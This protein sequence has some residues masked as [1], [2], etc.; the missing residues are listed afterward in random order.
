[1]SRKNKTV[2]NTNKGLLTTLCV[3]FGTVIFEELLAILIVALVGL[4][5]NIHQLIQNIPWLAHCVINVNSLFENPITNRGDLVAFLAISAQITFLTTSLLGGLSDKTERIYWITYPEEYLI[6]SRLNFENLSVIS[7]TSIGVQFVIMLLSYNGKE[8]F[9]NVFFM[10]AF[11]ISIIAIVILNYRF[12][13]VF[14]NREKICK[15]KEKEFERLLDERNAYSNGEDDNASELSK[16]LMV[17]IDK[18]HNYTIDAADNRLFS[19][20]YENVSL[21]LKYYDKGNDY[22]K[23]SIH[24]LLYKLL[25]KYPE[26][27]YQEV[28]RIA[29]GEQYGLQTIREVVREYGVKSGVDSELYEFVRLH[30]RYED[31]LAECAKVY[32]KLNKEVSDYYKFGDYETGDID[33]QETELQKK[34]IEIS[35]MARDVLDIQESKKNTRTLVSIVKELGFVLDT[36]DVKLQNNKVISELI[37]LRWQDVVDG[38]IDS[39]D[40]LNF[41]DFKSLME[42]VKSFINKYNDEIDRVELSIPIGH[43]I[44][45]KSSNNIIIELHNIFNDFVVKAI[46]TKEKSTFDVYIDMMGYLQGKKWVW[47]YIVDEISK[48]RISE[49]QLKILND[50]IQNSSMKQMLSIIFREK[51]D[52]YEKLFIEKLKDNGGSIALKTRKGEGGITECIAI[53]SE[54]KEYIRYIENV[55]NF[56]VNGFFEVSVRNFVQRVLSRVIVTNETGNIMEFHWSGEKQGMLNMN[57]FILFYNICKESDASF[58]EFLDALQITTRWKE[59]YEEYDEDKPNFVSYIYDDEKELDYYRKEV[60]DFIKYLEEKSADDEREKRI[61]V[62]TCLLVHPSLNFLIGYDEKNDFYNIVEKYIALIQSDSDRENVAN[63]LKSL[64]QTDFI[65]FEGRNALMDSVDNSSWQIF[66]I[67]I[68]N[69]YHRNINS[70]KKLTNVKIDMDKLREERDRSFDEESK[71]FREMFW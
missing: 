33:K 69:N 45:V 49:D 57:R 9:M 60:V 16:K 39:I 66:D 32:K 64:G 71:A 56:L 38:L 31:E 28:A 6:N 35:V 5:H 2:R 44:I 26:I 19:I 7:Y 36:L 63:T 12:T 53:C 47:S 1:M 48:E 37:K 62:L 18:L 42:Y 67:E 22:Y 17:I 68:S 46:G 59:Y 58:V 27:F 3:F 52:N 34:E 21:F 23:N 65:I 15:S 70:I 43:E 51:L 54:Y 29:D 11:A 41:N 30:L 4:A 13:S 50:I 61:Q 20:V 55:L 8:L 24:T 10:V 40:T 14:F 25:S